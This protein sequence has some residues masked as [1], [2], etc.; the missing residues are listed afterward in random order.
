MIT[1]WTG[2]TSSQVGMKL[3]RTLTSGQLVLKLIVA[4]LAT[5]SDGLFAVNFWPSWPEVN[6]V[7][8]GH[9][10]YVRNFCPWWAEV[11]M[12]TK[13]VPIFHS[14]NFGPSWSEVGNPRH[15]GTNYLAGSK[16]KMCAKLAHILEKPIVIKLR[17][18][19]ALFIETR[20]WKCGTTCPTF[21]RRRLTTENKDK[22]S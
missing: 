2:V 20:C 10:F 8:V 9:H 5:I 4:K 3:R 12:W 15:D 7:Q 22:L 1:S 11:E 6:G 13:L 16:A 17:Q 21:L 14:R 19:G 18:V